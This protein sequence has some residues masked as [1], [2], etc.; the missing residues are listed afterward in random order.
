MPSEAYGGK[1]KKFFLLNIPHKLI[2]G[3]QQAIMIQYTEKYKCTESSV[4]CADRC[5]SVSTLIKI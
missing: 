1:G 4:Y 2:F 5:P 3:S